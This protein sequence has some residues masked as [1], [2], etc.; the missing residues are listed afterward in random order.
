[1]AGAIAQHKGWRWVEWATIWLAA[2]TIVWGLGMKETYK[3]AILRKVSVSEQHQ[4]QRIRRPTIV[5]IK[6]FLSTSLVR[7]L[8]MLATEFIVLS[9]GLYVALSFG[10]LYTFF[11][12]IPKALEEAY[13]FNSTNSGLV[14][15]AI[16]I[17]CILATIT[18]VVWDLYGPRDTFMQSG[19]QM[20]PERILVPAVIGSF[21]L[22][23]GL[24]WFGFTA[25]KDIH[26]LV[27]VCSLVLYAWGHLLIFV[28]NFYGVR[29]LL[30]LIAGSLPR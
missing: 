3:K 1:M 11:A 17:G 14:F 12:V 13:N 23:I 20:R 6:Q 15:I 4:Q 26:W 22:P 29:H 8:A 18:A 19:E 30:I 21:G 28:S 2:A 10:I 25:R 16:A 5:E 7:P 9:L 27:P 24:F